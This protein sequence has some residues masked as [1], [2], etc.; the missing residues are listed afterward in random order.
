MRDKLVLAT[1]R[2]LGQV[3]KQ[4]PPK[5]ITY[6]LVIR[7]ISIGDV[8]FLTPFLRELKK[9]FPSAK[10]H[11]VSVGWAK[12]VLRHNPNVD[13]IWENNT[14]LNGTVNILKRYWYFFKLARRQK[15]DVVFY[16]YPTPRRFV[17]YELL[18]FGR[19]YRLGFSLD[20]EGT[21]T[22]D[23]AMLDNFVYY[24]TDGKPRYRLL[25][26]SNL[27]VL[28]LLVGKKI[29]AEGGLEIFTSSKEKEKIEHLLETRGW[30]SGKTLI[31]IGATAGNATKPEAAIKTLPSYKMVKV[32]KDLHTAQPN[33]IILF[34]GASSEKQYV[35]QLGICDDKEFVNLCGQFSL[36][37]SAELLKQCSLLISADTGIAHVGAA[38]K[39]NQIVLF[40][41][42]N[43]LEY[44]PYQNPNAV[45]M[46]EMLPCTPCMKITCDVAEQEIG[47]NLQ[48]PYCM[49]AIDT[50][51]IQKNAEAM[52]AV[53]LIKKY[54]NRI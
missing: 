24:K 5:V 39:M 21:Y 37:E 42:T 17:K 54:E 47:L 51:K 26:A 30:Q 38:L 45:V 2:L 36:T 13:Y 32:A 48:R 50:E 12:D 3:R 19:S 14:S 11:F 8:L 4:V 27:D 18:A 49:D 33:R 43:E 6:I 25:P 41:P 34:F 29:N 31:A 1:L 35:E 53:S 9:E 44:G 46:R 15:Y 40:G 16:M 7:E 28:E 22:T 52:L 10:V 20:K 23:N